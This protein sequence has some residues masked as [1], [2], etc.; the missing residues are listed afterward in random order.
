MPFPDLSVADVVFSK[1]EKLREVNR[2]LQKKSAYIDDLE[3]KYT[4]S[5]KFKHL[6][7]L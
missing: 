6:L 7:S 1:R 4:S 3:P 2:E 5:C